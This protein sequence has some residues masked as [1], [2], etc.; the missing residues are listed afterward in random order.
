MEVLDTSFLLLL[1]SSLVLPARRLP[2]E[3]AV[4]IGVELGGDRFEIELEVLGD[5]LSDLRRR[6]RE[7]KSA[8]G[9]RAFSIRKRNKERTS[10]FSCGIER[11]S[12]SQR[13]G[14]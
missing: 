6:E 4:D 8:K 9:Q 7:R 1:L 2:M 14:F 3:P 12:L 11:E 10:V 5:E 13:K